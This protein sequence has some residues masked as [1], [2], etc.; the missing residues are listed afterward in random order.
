MKAWKLYTVALV[1]FVVPAVM[2]LAGLVALTRAAAEMDAVPSGASLGMAAMAADDQDSPA[3]KIEEE[4]A[5]R[6]E[7]IARKNR[8][9]ATTCPDGFVMSEGRHCIPASGATQK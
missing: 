1:V 6:Y 7:E 4:R 9:D 3:A 2:M 8:E 5:I